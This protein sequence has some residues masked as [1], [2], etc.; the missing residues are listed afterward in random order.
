M[1]DARPSPLPPG[2]L[3]CRGRRLG[4]ERDDD[5]DRLAGG[6]VGQVLHQGH[7]V[8]V[9]PVQILQGD[10]Q[11]IRPHPAQ[12]PEHRLPLTAASPPTRSGQPHR[13]PATLPAAGR[14]G[15]AAMAPATGHRAADVCA[16]AAAAPQSQ[17]G[18]GRWQRQG[19]PGP[20]RPAPAAGRHPRQLPDQAGLADAGL[21]RDDGAATP[22][23][24]HSGKGRLQ[25][26]DLGPPPH[27][28][29]AQHLPHHP[30]VP[31]RRQGRSAITRPT[32]ARASG[33]RTYPPRPS[34]ATAQNARIWTAILVI[35]IERASDHQAVIWSRP[36]LCRA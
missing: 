15:A 4:A 20:S 10:H 29:R 5:E 34:T 25:R 16:A 19:R 22:A 9:R 26:L 32:P 24:E 30:S 17:A 33:C 7:R 13:S 12:Q 18:T 36:C 28:D 31:H 11:P 27:Q 6:V 14:P 21:T 8:G 2:Q 35:G 1:H 3:R 23:G